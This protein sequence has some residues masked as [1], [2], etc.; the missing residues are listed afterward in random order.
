MVGDTLLAALIAVFDV[1]IYIARVFSEPNVE[2]V[3]QPWYVT[4]PLIVGV[5][6]PMVFRRRYPIT[7]A[8]LTLTIGIA[9]SLL[10]I[11]IASMITSCVAL[12]T[13][14]AYVS[15]RT[16]LLYLAV[17]EVITLVQ[18]PWQFP[19]DWVVTL[20]VVNLSLAFSWALG[21]FNGC[22]YWRPNGT[23]RRGSRSPRSAPG[24]PASCTTWSRTRSASWWCRPTAPPTPCVASRN[25]RNGP[26]RPSPAPDVRR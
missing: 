10:E 20:I 16:A 8:Y 4:L 26:S 18:T 21:E 17:T 13:L 7:A 9:H 23:S 24:S 1:L 5:V 22:G 11:G 12:Y 14:V 3:P 25:S 19:E 2:P 6:A 15:R